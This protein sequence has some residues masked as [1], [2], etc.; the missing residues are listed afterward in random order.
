MTDILFDLESKIREWLDSILNP[1]R[2]GLQEGKTPEAPL[3]EPEKI[4]SPKE[5]PPTLLPP[6]KTTV[7][8]TPPQKTKG[9]LRMIENQ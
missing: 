7:E 2:L 4:E 5:T 1:N 8:G 3:P 6:K 9:N